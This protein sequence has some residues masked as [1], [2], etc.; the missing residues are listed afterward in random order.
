MSSLSV[1]V[2][3]DAD[4][5]GAAVAREIADLVLSAQKPVVLGLATG[6]TPIPVY[7]HLVALL[8]GQG[9]L[10]H[11][12]TFNLDEYEGLAPDN[13][14]SYRYFMHEHLFRH[15]SIPPSQIHFPGGA[16][17]Y[18]AQIAAAG[19][20]DIQVLLVIV[21]CCFHFCSSQLLGIG[22]NGH[23]GFNEPGSEA[24][25]RTR[26]VE[27]SEETR[28][29]NARFFGGDVGATPSHAITMGVATIAAARRVVLGATG[30]GKAEIMARLLGAGAGPYTPELPASVL[31]RHAGCVF[32]LDAAAAAQLKK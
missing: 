22:V 8:Q 1:V 12:H 30:A 4:A 26:R 14:Q 28:R 10:S 18:D 19:G 23:I 13:E 17:D 31:L 29:A 20:I 5:F 11:V 6:S 27:L 15:L 32:H 25:S 9:D 24:G 3:Q 16:G 2:H 21:V 7:K